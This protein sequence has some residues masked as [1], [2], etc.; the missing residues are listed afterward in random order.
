MKTSMSLLESDGFVG[1]H[2]FAP[3]SWQ[4]I[5]LVAAAIR[6]GIWD[7]VSAG[8]AMSAEAVAV[9]N[10]LDERATSMVLEALVGCGYLE[11]RGSDY[12]PS[13]PAL[14]KLG[15]V[16]TPERLRFTVLHL[17]RLARHWTTLDE[18]LATG[19]PL[20]PEE[21]F[22]ET[23]EGFV[24]AMDAYAGPTATE[25]VEVCL[26]MREEAQSVLDI[27]AATGT[28]SKL[29]AESGRQVTM[30][31]LP[32]V[33]EMAERDID[34]PDI[35]FHGGDFNE[36]L[37]D[38]PFDIVYLGN[39]VHIYSPVHNQ[40]LLQRVFAC[41][42]PGGLIAI[43]DYVRGRSYSAPFFGI[44]MLVNTGAGDAW[45]ENEYREWLESAGF[46]D[47][48][49]RDMRERDQQLITGRKR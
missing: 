31:D 46:T 22:S 49:L 4:E 19:R 28:V 6:T 20:A 3:G 5:F 43:L 15:T 41:L 13:Q 18:V 30:F 10:G 12:L 9:K 25:A 42:A 33:I 23:V 44:N 27:G 40:R 35:M 48:E 2:W 16:A 47:I 26:A 32:E 36:A 8:G 24:K 34:H 17:D 1:R 14:D 39:V 38:G 37:P 45:T 21:R 29:F 11:K 7:T